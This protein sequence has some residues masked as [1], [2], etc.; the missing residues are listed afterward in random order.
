MFKYFY[1]VIVIFVLSC[2]QKGN[3][4][5]RQDVVESK[6]ENLIDSSVKII[7]KDTLRIPIVHHIS[8]NDNGINPS[9]TNSAIQRVLGFI[10]NN[11]KAAKI[12]FYTK[13][14]K[15]IDNSAWNLSFSKQD[16]FRGKRVLKSFEDDEALN[17]FYFNQITSNGN[18]IG[19]TAFFPDEGNNVKFSSSTV[20]VSNTATATHEIGH[21]LGL[22]HIDDDFRDS[23]GRIE[24]VDGSNCVEAGDKICDTP[25]SPVLN[26]RNTVDCFYVGNATDP[27][28]V[29]YNPDIYNFMMASGRTRGDSQGLCRREFTKGQIEKMIEVLNNERSYLITRE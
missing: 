27:N 14:I 26:D 16:D 23:Q 29:P 28:G 4:V 3:F 25:A 2:N 20:A 13:A 18:G 17:I 19:A 5:I 24:L 9:V 21:Y 7:S 10:N 22:Y 8:R 12:Q 1:L 11:Y 6:D 15:N